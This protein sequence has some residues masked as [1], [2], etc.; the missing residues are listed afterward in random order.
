M[1][2]P[3]EKEN[4]GKPIS[5]PSKQ[6]DIKYKFRALKVHSSDEWMAD[7]TKKY[8]RVY[9]RFETTYIRVEVSFFNKLFDEEDWEATITTKCFFLN[10]NQKNELC[11]QDQQRKILKDENIVYIRDSWGNA[12]PGAY[13]NKGNY[14]WEAFVDNVLVGEA[15]F[16]VEDVGPSNPGE[17][18]YFKIEGIK[19]F[20]GDGSASEQPAKKY[21]SKFSQKDTRYV[22]GEF[23]FNNL[24]ANDYYAELFFNF[25]DKAGLFKGSNATLTFVKANTQN[26]VYT[27]Y[28]G[29]GGESPG[30]WKSDSYTM[31]VVFLDNLIATIPFQVGE[32]FEEGSAAVITDLGQVISQAAKP[33]STTQLIKIWTICCMKV[34]PNSTP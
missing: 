28:A 9:D 14:Q 22:W 33:T 8:R 1:E 31:E 25:Y 5:N 24:S 17:N 34:W 21:L 10:G 29:W 30:R 26:Q 32:A 7:G 13:W 15:K 20:E 16:Y 23:T 2:S 3:N 11:S 27:V 6:M 12:T 18:L 4:K 19:L